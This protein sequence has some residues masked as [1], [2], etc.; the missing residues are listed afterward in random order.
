MIQMQRAF[1]NSN[2]TN[3]EDI[4]IRLSELISITKTNAETVKNLRKNYKNKFT[5]MSPGG[6]PSRVQEKKI[7][8][9][10]Q[11]RIKPQMTRTYNNAV[12]SLASIQ[13]EW[14]TIDK[15]LY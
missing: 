3:K 14:S 6:I 13:A 11:T 1:D 10:Y 7:K 2:F 5:Y 15:Q 12:S 9:I 4:K 8:H